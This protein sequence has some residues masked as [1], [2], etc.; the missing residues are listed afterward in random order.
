VHLITQLIT[1]VVKKT[2]A[3]ENSDVIT[4]MNRLT[5]QVKDVRI[6]LTKIVKMEAPG[7]YWSEELSGYLI[8]N[9]ERYYPRRCGTIDE[10]VWIVLSSADVG[11]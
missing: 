9:N 2:I 5:R 1:K 10:K 4:I 3:G 6:D 7:W 11:E 8:F